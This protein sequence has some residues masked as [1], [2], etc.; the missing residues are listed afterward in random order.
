MVY[1]DGDNN[2]EGAGIDDFFE[3]ATVGSDSNVNIL[4]QL[5][6]ITGYDTSYD[7][8]TG[9][10]RYRV[11]NGMTPTAA[12]A[13]VDLGEVDMA[14]PAEV[15]DFVNWSVNN[16]PADNYILILW[17][18]GSG[19]KTARAASADSVVRWLPWEDDKTEERTTASSGEEPPLFTELIEKL[20][21]KNATV[22]RNAPVIE[23]ETIIKGIIYDDTQG[24]S[25]SMAELQQALQGIRDNGIDL[26]VLGFDACLMQMVEVVYESRVN[27]DVVVGS[28]E[29]EPWDGW[30]YDPVLADLTANYNWTPY[31]LSNEIVTEY[32]I[33]YAGGWDETQSA[34]DQANFSNLTVSIDTFAQELNNSLAAYDEEIQ[35]ARSGAQ[36]Y[37]YS[38]YVDLYDFAERVYGKVTNATIQNAAMQVMID[39]NRTV[40]AETHNPGASGSHGLSIWFPKGLVDL[41]SYKTL[42]FA[43]DTAWDEFLAGYAG[44]FELDAYEPDNDFANATNISADGTPQHHTFVPEYDMD[45]V[46]FAAEGGK[47]YVVETSNLTNGANTVIGLFDSNETFLAVNQDGGDEPLASKII[48]YAEENATY[49]VAAIDYW[50]S[51]GGVYDI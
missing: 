1:I 48:L 17:N 26:D 42:D 8:W 11:L 34:V 38:D 18:H 13:L 44:S 27:S 35:N 28:E 39:I 23:E 10:K 16:Y 5:D 15:V 45:F 40:F 6:R 32:I 19:W 21:E 49:Y 31:Q 51:N 9:A 3:M 22:E 43:A 30:P 37:Y 12:N 4:V 14:D 7:D 29:V 25:L 36:E 47:F 33:S 2:L 24:T 41:T 50:G 20:D 46:K